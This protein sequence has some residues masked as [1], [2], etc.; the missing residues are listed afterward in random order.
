MC[1]IAGAIGIDGGANAERV[2]RMVQIQRHRGPDDQGIWAHGPVVLGHARLSIVDLTSAGHQPMLS[3]DGRLAIVFNGE[4]YNFRGL[5]RQL[6]S[7]GERFESE[8]DTEVILAAYR[9][10]GRECLSH[11]NGMWGLAIWD[12]ERRVLFCARDRLGVKP[13]Y[14]HVTAEGTFLFASE[15]K[16]IVAVVRV[17]PDHAH[18]A[19]FLRTSLMDD[20]ERTCFSGV[21]QLMAGCWLEVAVRAD[22][23]AVSTPTAYWSFDPEL[24]AARYDCGRP[25]ETLRGLLDDS[26]RLRLRADVP[27]GT[28]LSGGLDSSTIV[29]LASGALREPV[30]TFSSIYE[31]P[32]YDEARFVHKVNKAF[33]TTAK[34]VTPHPARLR[35]VLP[36]IA[37]HQDQPCAAPGVFSQWHVMEMAAGDVKVLL[38]GQGADELLAGYVPYYVDYARSVSRGALRRPSPAALYGA[39]LAGLWAARRLGVQTVSG[40][41]TAR[42]VRRNSEVRQDYLKD[43]LPNDAAVPRPGRVLDDPLGDRLIRDT[44]VVSLPALLRYEDRNSM[45]FSIEA[46]TPFLDYRIVEFALALPI[47]ERIHGPWTKYILRRAMDDVLPRDI[48]WRRDKMGYPTPLAEWLRGAFRR[49]AEE[50]IFSSALADRGI[51]DDVVVKKMWA[52]HLTGYVD[53]SRSIWRWLSLEQWFESCL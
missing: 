6:T 2:L 14:Y 44:F 18:I 46:R 42:R 9:R 25:V 35:D 4:I 13:F 22:T 8:T 38:D 16:A 28:C 30:R 21:R 12:A 11:F 48:T 43:N 40:M 7:L 15:I 17:G 26:V 31:V 33:N 27:V 47:A 1:G 39:A 19:R 52:E 10:W 24:A 20:V 50:I 3:R 41:L 34:V 36:R 29:A 49:D 23:V 53:H 5:R 45:A 37:Y 51:Y 32:G